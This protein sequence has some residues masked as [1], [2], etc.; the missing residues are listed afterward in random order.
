MKKKISILLVLCFIISSFSFSATA[1]ILDDLSV[2]TEDFGNLSSKN[3]V[4]YVP[5]EIVLV[6]NYLVDLSQYEGAGPFDFHGVTI[7]DIEP[8][9]FEKTEEEIAER[10]ERMGYFFSYAITVSPTIEVKSAVEFLNN[11]DQI[12]CAQPNYI[13]EYENSLTY[14][15]TSNALLSSNVTYTQWAHNN[16][17]M[18][19]VWNMGF[20]GSNNVIVAVL[21]SGFESHVDLENNLEIYSGY[22]AH[23]NN[24]VVN[25]SDNTHGNMIC[26]I[27][28]ADYDD[29][30][31]NGIC[32]SVSI[33]PI[34]LGTGT[35]HYSSICTGAEW[36]ADAGASI[37]NLSQKLAYDTTALQLIC[38]QNKILVV[39]S[40]GNNNLIMEHDPITVGKR[41]DDEYWIVV[42]AIDSTNNRANETSWGSDWSSIYC[43]LFAPGV[44]IASTS[45]NNGYIDDGGGTSYASPHVAAAC[46]LI[47]SHATHLTPLQVK[48]YLLNNVTVLNS[49]TDLCVANGKLNIKAAVTAIYNENRKTYGNYTKGDVNNDG[50]INTSDHTIVRNIYYGS[51][52]PTATQIRA[53]DIND[54][55]T[56]DIT[57]YLLVQR[58]SNKTYYFP[59][60]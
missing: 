1:D 42:G 2:S 41:H 6:A 35:A 47:M 10:I 17:E 24:F 13:F 26:G 23:N 55:G 7:T 40:A 22:D 56:V 16:L 9:F 11:C 58:Y 12:E 8:L 54:N 14:N 37:I 49:L 36:A 60:I 33:L 4:E 52:S 46:A 51:Y 25:D 21:D 20:T 15:D 19:S 30:G 48:N 53:A 31:V 27:I 3:I 50:Q 44:D 18:T 32:R 45:K 39:T 57:D 43:D 29:V 5:N 38:S 34:Q 59:P 28:G